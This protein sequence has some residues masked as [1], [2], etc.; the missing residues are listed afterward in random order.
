MAK[1]RTTIKELREKRRA[2]R[3][4]RREARQ[5]AIS[6]KKN[7]PDWDAKDC[8]D[9]A[10]EEMREDYGEDADIDWSGIINFLLEKVLPILLRIFV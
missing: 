3:A 2:E 10:A 8:C 9:L 1:S 6:I 7:N 5:R 4:L